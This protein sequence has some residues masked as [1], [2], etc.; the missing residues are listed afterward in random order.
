MSTISNHRLK[1]HETVNPRDK[2]IESLRESYET[3]GKKS[4]ILKICLLNFW[5]PYFPSEEVFCSYHDMNN[6]PSSSYRR[7]V[8]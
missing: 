4:L 5:K 2:R 3:L 8:L 1:S 7:K 6:Y